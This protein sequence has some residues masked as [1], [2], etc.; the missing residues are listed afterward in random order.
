M[1]IYAQSQICSESANDIAA[2]PSNAVEFQQN[3]TTP[4][5]PQAAS[6]TDR[7]IQKIMKMHDHWRH[8]LA[9]RRVLIRIVIC[10]GTTENPHLIVQKNEHNQRTEVIHQLWPLCL[11]RSNVNPSTLEKV[12]SKTMK[13][14]ITEDE[15]L[16]LASPWFSQF[17]YN[18]RRRLNDTLDSHTGFGLGDGAYGDVLTDKIWSAF[19]CLSDHLHTC[20]HFPTMDF[21]NS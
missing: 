10:C 19:R 4:T 3:A 8:P 20:S 15:I 2:G 5:E 12:I 1:S 13:K 6:A 11:I 17:N 21:T 7:S 16:K 18:V 9:H 14:P